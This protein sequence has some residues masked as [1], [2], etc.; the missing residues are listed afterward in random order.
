MIIDKHNFGKS[1]I[2]F[3][4]EAEPESD[5]SVDVVVMYF[6]FSIFFDQNRS[7]NYGNR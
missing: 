7:F 5:M 1:L 4:F 3:S 2:F 6:M